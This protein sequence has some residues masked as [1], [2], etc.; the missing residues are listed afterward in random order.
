MTSEIGKG[1]ERITRYRS[2]CWLKERKWKWEWKGWKEGERAKEM[3]EVYVNNYRR[4][5][6]LFHAAMIDP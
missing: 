2:G 4:G 5:L 1:C 3:K 6:G